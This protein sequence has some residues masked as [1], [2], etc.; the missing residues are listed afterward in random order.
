MENIVNSTS[1]EDY[2]AVDNAVKDIANIIS[3]LVSWKLNRMGNPECNEMRFGYHSDAAEIFFMNMADDI[4]GYLCDIET[5][6]S[7]NDM[8]DVEPLLTSRHEEVVNPITNNEIDDIP[9]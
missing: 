8:K 2:K 1:S 5:I 3:E 6:Y 4:F 9:F 7:A